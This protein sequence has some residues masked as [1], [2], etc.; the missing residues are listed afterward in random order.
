M[1]QS[2]KSYIDPTVLTVRLDLPLE[3]KSQK[4]RESL[5]FWADSTHQI[6]DFKKILHQMLG[7]PSLED[8]IFLISQVAT[9]SDVPYHI[10][11]KN[12]TLFH[13]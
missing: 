3:E 1:V 13:I 12:F 8:T 4:G 5:P 6:C 10:L 9:M 7:F 11:I 2:I